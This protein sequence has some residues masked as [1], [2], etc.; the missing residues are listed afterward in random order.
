[1]FT[2]HVTASLEA[3]LDQQLSAAERQQVEAHIS[4]CPACAYQLE[5]A[6]RLALELKPTLNAAFGR[7]LPPHAL[8]QRVRQ[9]ITETPERSSFFQ[10]VA[11]GR[12]LNAVGTAAVIAMF[13]FGAWT[14]IQGQLPGAGVITQINP[15]ESAQNQ[16]SSETFTP[17]S[18]APTSTPAPTA[19]NVTL[20]DELPSPTPAV[21]QAA[22]ATATP[23]SAATSKPA[24]QKTSVALSP[25]A[26]PSPV[27][28]VSLPG[29]TIAFSFFN[30]AS[31]REAYEIHLIE[32][33][34]SNHQIFPLD[35][36]SEPALNVL[37]STYQIAFR[38]WG[39]QTTPRSL[40]SST[41][42]GEPRYPLGGFWEDASPDW[43]P[44][45]NRVIFSSQRE[46]DRRW[47]L[48]TI[49]ADGS[50]EKNLRREGNAP[51]FAPDGYR[52]AFEGCD[53]TNNQCGLWVG[54]LEH[55]EFDSKPF[56]T[57][58]RAKSPDWSPVGE[59]IAYMA[60]LNGNWDLYV[61]NSDGSQNRRLTDDAAVDGLP[62]WSPDGK[63]LAFLSNRGDNWGIWLLNVANGHTQQVSAFDGGIFTPPTRAPFGD[64]NWWDEQISWAK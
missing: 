13:A 63:W 5:V 59:E 50:A 31:N 17:L 11:P 34:G 54:D 2:K 18:D 37:T 51:T 23:L 44:T 43:S 32:P 41:L 60:D 30:A 19:A 16:E 55:S 45:E 7:P 58:P 20:G 21:T 15:L 61:V 22:Q 29:G 8:R 46:S 27:P 6:R 25:Q 10:W 3:Y 38:A 53:N 26:K 14:V 49:W 4:T 35:G 42:A 24:A 39:E 62:A 33:D 40:L 52:F 36:V 56:L 12:V 1:M 57:N 28:P 9:A 64:R 48:Y 47:R